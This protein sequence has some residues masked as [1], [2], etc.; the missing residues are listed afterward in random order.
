V[1]NSTP[2]RE[3]LAYWL[4]VLGVAP[5]DSWLEEPAAE[6][7]PDFTERLQRAL[8]EADD[9]SAVRTIEGADP[10]EAVVRIVALR[11]E[12]RRSKDW[13]ASDRLRDALGRCGV[14]VKDS[15]DGTTWI[16]AAAK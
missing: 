12:A 3:R 2:S 9:D 14:D 11:D 5:N 10:N 7:A 8:R 1:S 15:K 16:V 4:G 6:L 13:A